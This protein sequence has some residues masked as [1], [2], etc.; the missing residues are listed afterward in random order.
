[1]NLS[2][3]YLLAPKSRG[4]KLDYLGL[5]LASRISYSS[6]LEP[7]TSFHGA[8]VSPHIKG[9]LQSTELIESNKLEFIAKAH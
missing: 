9:E 8:S 7:V 2:P 6:D 5:S 4:T 1:M 3:F